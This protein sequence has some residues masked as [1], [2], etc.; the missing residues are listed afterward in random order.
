MM[1]KFINIAQIAASVLLIVFIILQ[2]K[3]AGL[4]GVFGGEGNVYQT[5]RGAEKI[6]FISTIVVAILFMGIAVVN[7]IF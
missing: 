5:R 3:G 2:N 6:L 7:L 4:G 1:E